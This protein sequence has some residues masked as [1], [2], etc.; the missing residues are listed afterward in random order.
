MQLKIIIITQDHTADKAIGPGE[1]KYIQNQVSLRL[2][3][4]QSRQSAGSVGMGVS[5][6]TNMRLP[7]APALITCLSGQLKS[8]Q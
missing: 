5:G 4:E 1:L 2:I 7:K 3:V 8:P 6:A